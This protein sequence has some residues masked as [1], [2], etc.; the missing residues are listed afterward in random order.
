[1]SQERRIVEW[2]DSQGRSTAKRRVSCIM[3]DV[4]DFDHDHDVRACDKFKEIAWGQRRELAVRQALCLQCLCHGTDDLQRSKVCKKRHEGPHRLVR[5]EVERPYIPALPAYKKIPGR[6]EYSCRMP[7]SIKTGRG[8]VVRQVVMQAS[9]N[10][11]LST[12]LVKESVAIELGL[13]YQEVKQQQVW[14]PGEGA[15][16]TKRIYF[17][18][19]QLY[20]PRQASF[21]L[22]AAYGVEDTGPRLKEA[23]SLEMA[24]TRFS[25]RPRGRNEMFRQDPSEAQVLIGTD[26]PYLF[27]VR[28]CKSQLKEDDLYYMTCVLAPGMLVYGEAGLG[29][30]SQKQK[31]DVTGQGSLQPAGRRPVQRFLEEE[32]RADLERC[33]SFDS[34]P[35]SPLRRVVR[36]RSS[37]SSVMEV[38][39]S[40]P[41]RTCG[42]GPEAGSI[43]QMRTPVRTA[44][45]SKRP[46]TP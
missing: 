36:R 12:T 45:D 22:F 44:E 17:L 11:D 21:T 10:Q 42:K 8:G 20:C 24:R 13:P 28:D 41:R 7:I 23:P 4:C 32:A 19:A 29:K 31:Q 25:T 2:R 1:M 9:F 46:D 3:G 27:P 5:P 38:S 26:Y 39:P 18:E 6:V 34:R 33:K 43:S 16:A 14:R 40:P 35:G 37:D 30:A 15:Q